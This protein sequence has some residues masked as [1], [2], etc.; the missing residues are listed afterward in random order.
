MTGKNEAESQ[1]RKKGDRC[2]KC[3]DWFNDYGD[4]DGVCCCPS[5]PNHDGVM[6]KDGYC[7]QFAL[8]A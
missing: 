2:G 6:P 8:E 3:V 5:S 4:T 7:E 1:K